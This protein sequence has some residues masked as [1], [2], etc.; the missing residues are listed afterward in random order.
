[1]DPMNGLRPSQ[2]IRERRWWIFA[3]VCLSLLVIIMDNTI[4]NVALPTLARARSQREPAPMV[5]GRLHPGLCR[6][7]PQ[8]GQFL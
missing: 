6:P 2:P 8:R 4:L 5:C 7:A 1:M 3:L